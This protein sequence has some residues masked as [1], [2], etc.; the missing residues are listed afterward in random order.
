MYCRPHVK[1]LQRQHPEYSYLKAFWLTIKKGG[2]NNSSG[3]TRTR[4]RSNLIRNKVF[5]DRLERN[6]KDRMQSI[7]QNPRGQGIHANLNIFESSDEENSGYDSNIPLPV[8]GNVKTL[9]GNA[10]K[11]CGVET[12]ISTEV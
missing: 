3:Q 4:R 1:A 11:S 10:V 12:A 2:D 8:G 5:L 7:R 6:H 9:P